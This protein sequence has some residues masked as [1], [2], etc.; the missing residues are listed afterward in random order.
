MRE[1]LERLCRLTGAATAAGTPR[2]PV[3]RGALAELL[4]FL[5]QEIAS[6]M[7]KEE[8]A[9][10]PLLARVIGREGP[11]AAVEAQ[12]QAVDETLATLL[13]LAGAAHLDPEALAEHAAEL[14]RWLEVHM[15]QEEELLFPMLESILDEAMDQELILKM[16]AIQQ[17][18][19]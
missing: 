6:H 16:S 18:F 17:R 8:E 7:A 13:E 12:H 3:D 5:A 1:A 2:V 11:L 9:C 14:A 19:A 10:F 15:S 4:D